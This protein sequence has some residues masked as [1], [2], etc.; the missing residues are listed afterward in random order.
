MNKKLILFD[1]DGTLMYHVGARHWNEQYA[2]GMKVAYGITDQIDFSVYNGSIERH[3][4]WDVAQKYHISREEFFAKFPLYV[5]AMRKLLEEWQK[6]GEVF[7]AIPEAV[8]LVE[9]LSEHKEYV[10]GILTGNAESI[11]HWKLKHV[12]INGYFSFGLYGEEADDRISLAKLVFEKAKKELH[13]EFAL[14]DI[15]VI[16]DTVH[17]IRCGKAIGAVTIAVT[18]GMHGDSSVL[19][20]EKPNLLVDTL[21][22]SRVEKVLLTI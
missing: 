5:A 10:L 1:I 6:E 19:E 8:S 3:M 14:Q 16:G 4:A 2:H 21:A 12:G 20:T 15:V 7:K 18:T 17:D 13:E 22:D 11:A 9:K